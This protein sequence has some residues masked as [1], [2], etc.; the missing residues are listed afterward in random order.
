MHRERGKF[1]I[2]TKIEN[3]P[4]MQDRKG[5]KLRCARAALCLWGLSQ[6]YVR[7]INYGPVLHNYGALPQTYEDPSVP[8]PAADNLRGD[9]DPLDV[10]DIGQQTAT[11]GEV[12][13]VRIL[14]ALGLVDEGECDWKLLAVRASDPHAA[15]YRGA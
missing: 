5:G 15:V 7:F 12:Y 14:G 13:E 10:L 1:E 11:L 6:P 3:N 8:Q 4:I 2:N 9:G